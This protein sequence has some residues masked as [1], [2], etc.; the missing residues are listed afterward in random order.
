MKYTNVT[1]CSI[2]HLIKSEKKML[3]HEVHFQ[4]TEH[5]L[6]KKKYGMLPQ[7]VTSFSYQ[8][9]FFYLTRT[10]PSEACIIDRSIHAG[11]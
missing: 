6:P 7:N 2:H 8:G 11:L 4:E 5:F 1:G 9:T 10:Y 3:L